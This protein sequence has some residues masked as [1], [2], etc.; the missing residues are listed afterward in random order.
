MIC[1]LTYYSSFPEPNKCDGTSE[2]T[3]SGPPT[4]ESGWSSL[5]LDY[6]VEWPLHILFTQGVVDK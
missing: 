1:Q 4:A 5:C 3:L 2:I 6:N